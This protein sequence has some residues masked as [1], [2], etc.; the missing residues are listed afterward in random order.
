MLFHTI[1]HSRNT[2]LKVRSKDFN[3]TSTAEHGITNVKKSW[4]TIN[5]STD[6]LVIKLCEVYTCL[7][8][9]RFYSF[10]LYV[11]SCLLACPL[12]YLEGYTSPGK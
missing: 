11:V 5:N 6:V 12:I 2:L 3:S 7:F 8:P 1:C 9:V 4:P 10:E